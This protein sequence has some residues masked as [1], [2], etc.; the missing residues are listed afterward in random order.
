M[1]TIA[2]GGNQ[3][4]QGLSTP[5]V[6]AQALTVLRDAGV[7]PYRASHLYYTRP[8]GPP[9][10]PYINAV[11]AIRYM[12]SATALMR[13][14]H[15]V[16]DQFQRQRHQKWG[17]RT[18][19][20]DLIDFHGAVRSGEV[21][22]PHPR[23]ADRAFVLMPL[24]DVAPQ[25]QHPLTRKS[26]HTLIADLSVAQKHNILGRSQ[27]RFSLQKEGDAPKNQSYSIK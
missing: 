22:L 21:L 1:I 4:W 24:C 6:F 17:A 3:L 20:L 25:W 7:T 18:L 16:E 19:D 8:V 13:V 27:R 10:D 9:Q 2:M 15:A 5:Q 12:R 11:I 14:L 23:M 26:I